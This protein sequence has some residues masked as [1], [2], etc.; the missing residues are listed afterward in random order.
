[1]FDS[2]DAEVLKL[3]ALGT[4]MLEQVVWVIVSGP[5]CTPAPARE[6]ALTHP[7]ANPVTF[8]VSGAMGP[9]S[10]R[11]VDGSLMRPAGKSKK[12][13]HHEIFIFREAVPPSPVP[14]CSRY[15]P[16]VMDHVSKPDHAGVGAF[17]AVDLFV[18]GLA[19]MPTGLVQ[20][21]RRKWE[22]IRVFHH[23]CG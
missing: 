8:S 10:S 3:S 21:P 23:H 18:S 20:G 13:P 14:S 16:R 5:P 15:R 2:R 1:V 7:E 9:R 11:K 22:G 19:E 4:Q 12:N 17:A 6:H